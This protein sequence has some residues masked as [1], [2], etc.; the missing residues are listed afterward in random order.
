MIRGWY[1]TSMRLVLISL[2]WLPFNLIQG[3]NYMNAIDSLQLALEQVTGTEERIDLLNE[4][5]YAYRRTDPNQVLSLARTAN[6]LSREAGYRSGMATSFKI[7]GIAYFKLGRP[8]DSTIFYYQKAITEAEAIDDHYTQAACNNN[9]GLVKNTAK[10]YYEAITYF[11]RCIRL[12]DSLEPTAHSLK[13]LALAN[14]A[15]THF[16]LDEYDKAI[17]KYE[18]ALNLAEAEDL[19]L[20]R[21][22]YL[23]NYARTFIAKGQYDRAEEILLEAISVQKNA[24]DYQS[25]GQSYVELSELYK[26]LNRLPE[27]IDAAN[28][29]LAISEKHQFHYMRCN[30]LMLLATIMNRQENWQEGIRY[31]LLTLDAA[32]SSNNIIH[33]L[34]ACRALSTAYEALGNYQEALNYQKTY[35]ALFDSTT[36][37]EKRA[38]ATDIQSKYQ[39]EKIEDEI[40]ILNQQQQVQR[41]RFQLVVG[42]FTSAALLVILLIY[43]FWQR[44]KDHRIIQAKNQQLKDYIDYSLQLENFAHIASHDLR[45]PIRTIVSFSQLLK[46]RLGS[47]LDEAS[48]EY[49]DYIIQGTKEM[50]NLIE[51]LLAYSKL[52]KEQL[53]KEQVSVQKLL[54]SLLMS[55]GPAIAEQRAKVNYNGL[56]GLYVYADEIKLRQ[57]LQNLILNGIK[58]RHST[59]DPVIDISL[60]KQEQRWLF[61]VS[62]NGIGIEKEYQEKI[63]LIF[64]RL[65]NRE[66]FD[67]SGIG[68][69]ICKRIVELHGG[70]IWVESQAGAGSTFFFTIPTHSVTASISR[71]GKTLAEDLVHQ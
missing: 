28:N 13:I 20:L 32:R 6:Q 49:L 47:K 46:R 70:E 55:I 15:H 17:E 40:T 50:K 8:A 68:L 59:R 42:L 39:L 41:T 21:G 10:D 43:L 35:T 26:E 3:Q 19:P 29:A 45:T 71:P 57:L 4:L 62:D 52:N 67:G 44:G 34:S 48:A 7:I 64:K 36:Y 22:M 24:D 12:I 30:A 53:N 66:E 56:E 16:E 18:A 51:D 65:N 27:A 25:T 14:V 58:F 5:A 61:C 38:M 37:A 54:Q 60:R 11:Y 1:Y 63:F 2:L 9:I 33:E 69:A 23:D 31:G